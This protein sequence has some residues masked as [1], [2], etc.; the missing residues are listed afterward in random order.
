MDNMSNFAIFLGVLLCGVLSF[1]TFG[2]KG[3]AS[4]AFFIAGCIGLILIFMED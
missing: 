4:E 1:I 3:L 2:E